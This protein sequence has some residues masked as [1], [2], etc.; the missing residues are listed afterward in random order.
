MLIQMF[1]KPIRTKWTKKNDSAVTTAPHL[2]NYRAIP[3]Q[4]LM[5]PSLTTEVSLLIRLFQKAFVQQKYCRPA[6]ELS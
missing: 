4:L 6:L 2:A 3:R 1:L 5:L